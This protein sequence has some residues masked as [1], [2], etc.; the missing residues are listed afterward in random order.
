MKSKACNVALVVVLVV[1]GWALH[2][3]VSPYLN[4]RYGIDADRVGLVFVAAEVL[5]DLGIVMML[6]FA[7]VRRFSWKTLK[8]FKLKE[9]RPDWGNL[10]VLAGLWINRISWCVPF[11]YILYVGWHTLPWLV[12]FG[13]AVEIMITAWIGLAVFG[14]FRPVKPKAKVRVRRGTL[15]DLDQIVEVDRKV[16]GDIFPG[17]REMF[18][19]RI[20]TF[21]EAGVVVGEVDGEI[22][23]F[24]SGQLIRLDGKD[25]SRS[26]TWDEISDFGTIKNTHDPEGDWLYGVGL[27]STSKAA[28]HNIVPQLFEYL[29]KFVITKHKK[30][31]V[32]MARMPGYHRHA[33]KMSPAGYAIAKRNNVP[34]DPE[35]QLY[36]RY[37]MSVSNPPSVVKDYMGE[38]S[39]PE[40]CGW[41]VLVN[42]HNPVYAKPKFVRVLLAHF[43]KA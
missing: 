25:F 18:A 34:R 11:A 42:W 37:G 33:E 38:N 30:G 7:G 32:L 41:S 15:A 27:A 12:L 14:V 40:S 1:G 5:F 6:W 16:W 10:G 19:S 20:K 43:F 28:S 31:A 36:Q 17:S 2:Q 9:F 8:S 13:C 23:A 35:L 4:Q 26:F 3:S 24:V 39:D 22:V 29:A 21:P